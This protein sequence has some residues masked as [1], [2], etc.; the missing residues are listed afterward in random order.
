MMYII[1]KLK[2]MYD[3]GYI[4]LDYFFGL[5]IFF[6]LKLEFINDMCNFL[7]VM[8]DVFGCIFYFKFGFIVD[9]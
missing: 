7:V 2:N 6:L 5:Y 3:I 9:V 4:V 8:V 1:C